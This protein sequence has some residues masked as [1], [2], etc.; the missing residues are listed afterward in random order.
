VN[1]NKAELGKAVLPSVWGGGGVDVCIDLNYIVRLF[2]L[3]PTL[4]TQHI[5]RSELLLQQTLHS[6]RK[7]EW[8]CICLF[9]S[10]RVHLQFFILSK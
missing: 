1:S 9:V 7:T 4:G 2:V 3:R 5:N 8:K 6:S 10:A